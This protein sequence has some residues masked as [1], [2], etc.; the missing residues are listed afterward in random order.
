L[1]F[2]SD[3]PTGPSPQAPNGEKLPGATL[4]ATTGSR[5][6][7]VAELV[8]LGADRLA[9]ILVDVATGH[10]PALPAMR[11]AIR[12]AQS[13][14]EGVREAE[15]YM[16][17]A[18]PGMQRVYAD[19]RKFARND[20]PVLITGESGTGKELAARAIHERSP[21]A[22]G[23][24]VAINCAALPS[25]LVSSELFGYEKGAFTGAAQRRIGFIELANGGTLLLDEIGDLPL[26]QQAHLLRFLQE[27][28]IFRVGGTKAVEI[29]A[30]I[31]AAT[32][33][34]LSC[35]LREGRFREDLFYR[36]NI[37]RLHLPP[38][39]ERGDDIDLLCTFFLRKFAAEHRSCARDFD[40]EA[41]R[42]IRTHDWPG[43]VRELIACIRRGVVMAEGPLITAS[44][45]CLRQK[46]TPAVRQQQ[47]G[48]A[49]PDEIRTVLRALGGNVTATAQSLGI[50]RMTVYRA[51]RRTAPAG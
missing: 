16:V 46:D 13:A 2:S 48:S 8:P 11:E 9:Q 5:E 47:A 23:P 10:P 22:A 15:P 4:G 25:S 6:E 19:I 49:T 36:L 3:R 32:N 38:L 21:F 50:S 42:S 31:I 28:T 27:A 35:A 39:R 40:Q 51:L 7:L 45:L 44:D 18:S 20:A 37:L 41:W 34:D 33:T 26:E 14:S 1:R 17:G 29:H 30:R 43:N 12:L 24:F